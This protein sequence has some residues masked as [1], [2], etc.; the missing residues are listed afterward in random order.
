[1]TWSPEEFVGKARLYVERGLEAEDPAVR[2]WWFHF[3]VEP[4]VRAMVS[5]VHPVIL[6]DPRSTESL[7]AA[8]GEARDDS[9]I[10]R[11][12]GLAEL[13]DYSASLEVVT[14][15]AKDAAVR[16]VV[17][18]NAECHGPTAE[19]EELGEERWMPDFL[20][21]AG[22]F[23]KQCDI[24]LEDFVGSGYAE[25][26]LELETQTIKEAEAEVAKLVA[27]A[28]KRPLEEVELSAVTMIEKTS[29]E[30]LWAVDCPACTRRGEMAGVRVHVGA[31]RFDGDELSQPVSVA[32]RRFACPHCGLQL[33]GTAQLVAAELPATT[34][35]HDY[36][37]PFEAL[38]IDV[39]EEANNQGLEVIDP[40]YDGREYEDE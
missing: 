17:R 14:V 30:V 11:T 15:E 33:Q 40:T 39:V 35:T 8:V 28:R 22:A 1:M 21:L 29:G 6:A 25:Q 13:I 18:R 4:M 7:L 27:E 36:V 32:G 20:I 23:C 10:V 37:N 34:T 5:T 16:L 9:K 31:A 19:F 3:A 26:A 2:A 12:R 24:D 38:N